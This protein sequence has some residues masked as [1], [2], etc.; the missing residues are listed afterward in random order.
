MKMKEISIGKHTVKAQAVGFDKDGTLFDA[1]TY[2][3]TMDRI[4]KELFLK[5]VGSEHETAWE[6]IM[7]FVHPDHI[8]YSGVLAVATTEEEILLTAGV[9]F[10]L[11]GWPWFQCKQL[12]RDLFAQADEKLDFG[13]AFSPLCRGTRRAN[14]T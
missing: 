5:I 14:E 4:R 13:L 6:S 9:M 8:N 10:Q 1:L 2:W 7:G 12:A 3:R 11:H